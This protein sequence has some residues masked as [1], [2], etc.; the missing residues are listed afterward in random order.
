MNE[1]SFY[2]ISMLGTELEDYGPFPCDDMT[3]PERTKYGENLLM[4][5]NAMRE[6]R[7]RRQRSGDAP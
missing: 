2:S 4:L 3:G 7:L 6:L 5:A 1:R